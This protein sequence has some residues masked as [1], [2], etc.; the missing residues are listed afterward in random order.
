MSKVV[1]NCSVHCIL[2]NK[3][4]NVISPNVTIIQKQVI[5]VQR[6]IYR[7]GPVKRICLEKKV[8]SENV[9]VLFWWRPGGLNTCSLQMT[10][11]EAHPPSVV[12]YQYAYLQQAPSYIHINIMLENAVYV[13][14]TVHL[15]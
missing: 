6:S 8:T 3:Y 4:K 5:L 7:S 13:L 9:A 10:P 2:I 1:R 15:K 12:T 11:A 14:H